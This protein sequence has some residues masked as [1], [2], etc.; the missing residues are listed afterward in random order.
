MKKAKLLFPIFIVPLLFDCAANN[1]GTSSI[2]SKDYYLGDPSYSFNNGK[3]QIGF[4][5]KDFSSFNLYEKAA[6][7]SSYSLVGQINES[8][9]E[10]N[11]YASSFKVVGLIDGQENN[12][13][14]LEIKSYVEGTFASSNIKVFSP[15]NNHNEINNFIDTNYKKQRSDE[16]SSK[17]ME[18][19]FLPGNYEDVTLSLGY[20]MSARGLGSSPD[21][22]GFKNLIV[23][24]HPQTGNALINFW[25]SMENVSFIDNSEWAVSQGTSIRRSHFKGDL[26]LYNN[27]SASGGFIVNSK[28]D[29]TT[30]PGS[31]QQFLM[32]N[33]NINNWTHSNFNM[34]FEGCVGTF[35]NE[36]INEAKTTII[37]SS[38]D[39]IEKPYLILDEQRGLGF[40]NVNRKSDISYSW[41]NEDDEFI[42]LHDFVIFH[43]YDTATTINE[44]LKTHQYALFTPGVY[45]IDKT[46]EITLDNSLITGLGYATLSV[47]KDLDVLMSVK[48]KH[49]KISSLLFQ[50][51]AT[52][53][54][55]LVLE[56]RNDVLDNSLLSDLFF[57]VGG[58]AHNVTSVDACLIINQDKVIGDN[59][60]IWRADHGV[61]KREFIGFDKNY[62]KNGIIVNGNDVICHAL[63]VE[64]FFQYQTIWN[65]E[66]GKVVFYQSE[67]PY[68]PIDQTYWMRNDDTLSEAEKNG[69]PSYKI[70]NDVISHEAYGI[71]VYFVNTTDNTLY[72]Y[73]AMEA[74]AN[75][76][77][78]LKHL[79]SLNFSHNGEIVNTINS[80][81]GEEI[82]LGHFVLIFDKN[83]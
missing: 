67:T 8:K 12:N 66:R 36:N 64:H 32:R 48:S 13:Y 4:K 17:R 21:G 3:A 58:Q 50:S 46:I 79:I 52:I 83:S 62:A 6:N 28:I 63:M 5:S 10:T 30:N 27:G 23:R 41:S 16:W 59:F 18:M 40:V 56:E 47:S 45:N 76:E 20:Y 70:N 71:G 72:C 33:D 9:F 51:D 15:L 38:F 68:D 44:A 34:V 22:V 24:D 55:F 11:N 57:R 35:P 49:N 61:N 60:W 14:S 73:S 82:E 54:S 31:Q 26:N 39:V 7:A 53:N 19:L 43:P 77:I 65:G 25:R 69:Y 80:I 81:Q 37:E 2:V 29:G 75:E 74:P 1:D 78:F 42:S